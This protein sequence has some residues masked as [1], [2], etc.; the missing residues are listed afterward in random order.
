M[1]MVANGESAERTGGGLDVLIG[2]LAAVMRNG[3]LGPGEM[4][5][6]RRLDV[7][8][9]DQP[10]FWRLVAI[11]IAPDVELSPDQERKWAIVVSGMARMAPNIHDRGRPIGRVLAELH[12]AEGR[13]T[14][15][16][17]ARNGAMSPAVR[18]VAAMLAA[19][20]EAVDWIGLAA[21]VLTTDHDRREEIRLRIA[22]DYFSTV[23][24]Q[25]RRA[26][27]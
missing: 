6:L 8:S 5:Q 20:G 3:A 7:T 10:A 23:A 25:E 12:V 22:K 13:L 17:R 14:T 18:R 21:L 1:T 19:R 27:T 2:R 9:P 11:W 24:R 4:A 26:D 15:L 16:L